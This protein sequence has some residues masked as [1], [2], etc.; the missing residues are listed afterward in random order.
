M[1]FV[2]FVRFL[3]IYKKKMQ[4]KPLSNLR[5][6]RIVFKSTCMWNIILFKIND[7]FSGVNAILVFI[8]A[9]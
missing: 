2:L 7:V 4:V 3:F 8:S 5:L 1:L 9:H 6:N